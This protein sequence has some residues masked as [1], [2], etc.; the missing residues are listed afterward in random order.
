[1]DLFRVKSIDSML[2]QRRMAGLRKSLSTFDLVMLGVGAVV[3]SGIFILTGT[4]SLIAGP[5][6]SLSFVLAAVACFFSALS[7]AEFSSS[8]PVSGSV[9]T[10][11][12][13][14]LGELPAWLIG[15]ILILE[16]GLA[17][18][19]VAAGWSGYLQSLVAGLGLHLPEAL[20]AAPGAAAGSG[21]LFNLPAFLVLA[22]V[23]ALLSLGIRQSKRVNNA[24]V[25]IKILVVVLF[26]A[27]GASHVRTENWTPFMPYGMGGVYAGAALMFYAF[28]GFDAVASSAEEVRNP[29]RSLPLGILGSLLICTVLYVLVTLVMTGI[30]PYRDFASNADHPVSLAL[31]RTGQLGLAGVVDLGA[32]LGMTT[33]ILVMSYGLT[34]IL[35]AMARDGLLPR[36]L[37]S[38]HPRYATPFAL[39][40]SV[41]L[42]FALVAGLVPLAVLAELINI[43]TLAAFSLISLAVIV[44]RKT[45][46]GLQRGFRCPG[47]PYVPLAAVACCVFLIAH[48]DR[49]T[50][51]AFC[52]WVAAGLIVYF[53]Y[54]RRKSVL[55]ER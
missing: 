28:I 1:M 19:A 14:T 43:G 32:I 12:Y 55:A 45:H 50:W 31:Q 11:V 26:I 53:L 54:S 9:Y 13:A 49:I 30:V 23:T 5:A 8:L 42:V 51:L 18:S 37:A 38:L 46:P 20:R 44:L 52:L 2:A 15:W 24:M 3:G 4:G 21:S 27:A 47:V 41:G 29:Q 33:V 16:F 34:R 17:A 22:A 40:W 35:Y 48:L 25:V 7:Y 10:Y 36:R 39:T 6:L